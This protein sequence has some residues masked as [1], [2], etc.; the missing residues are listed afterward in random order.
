[1][2]KLIS[3]LI[4]SVMFCALFCGCAARVKKDIVGTWSAAGSDYASYFQPYGED[5]GKVWYYDWSGY[6]TYKIK[7]NKIIIYYKGEEKDYSYRYKYLN[8][9]LVLGY[10]N[11]Y[12]ASD[13]EG[14][15]YNIHKIS[16]KYEK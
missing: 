12:V 4:V 3:L 13:P 1:M 11:E 14:V 2:K 5:G 16:D 15:Q 6:D 10:Y 8:G 7:G 9:E